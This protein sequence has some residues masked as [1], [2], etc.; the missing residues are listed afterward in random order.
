MTTQPCLTTPSS[1]PTSSATSPPIAGRPA[2]AERELYRALY[3]SRPAYGDTDHSRPVRTLFQ[4]LRPR[5]VVDVGCGNGHFCRWARGLGCSPVVGVDLASRPTGAGVLWVHA[6]AAALPLPDRCV[7]WV[8][9]F[10]LLEHLHEDD[11]RRGVVEM[12]RVSRRGLLV[13]PAY[14]PSVARGPAGED[15]HL[16][17]EPPTWWLRLLHE[18]L[19]RHRLTLHRDASGSI[20][21][22]ADIK[23]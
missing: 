6:D 15:L 20:L 18:L 11:I 19:P 16:T 2:D 10:D 1:R 23:S 21:A 17:V 7:E 8:T 13:K 3:A 22:R 12:A 9:S 14:R 5:S 4:A